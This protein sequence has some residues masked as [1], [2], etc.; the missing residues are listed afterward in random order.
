MNECPAPSR[1]MPMMVL[2][3]MNRIRMCFTRGSP[4]PGVRNAMKSIARVQQ[5]EKFEHIVVELNHELTMIRKLMETQDQ[6]M[7]VLNNA[8]LSVFFG[9]STLLANFIYS[10]YLEDHLD[11]ITDGVLNAL[12]GCYHRRRHSVKL[13]ITSQV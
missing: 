13:H 6:L 1:V 12:N 11:P 9:A 10:K 2:E 4:P 7:L 8:A 3:M 5:M